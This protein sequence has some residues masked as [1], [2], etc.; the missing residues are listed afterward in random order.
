MSTLR[1]HAPAMPKL[2][3]LPAAILAR[4]VAMLTTAIDVFTEAQRLA[5]EA[6]KRYPYMNM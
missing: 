1:I 4:A 5:Q 3:S 6:Q 2:W